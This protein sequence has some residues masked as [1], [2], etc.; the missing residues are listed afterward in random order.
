MG[1]QTRAD[2]TDPP[3]PTLLDLA[4][5]FMN[6]GLTSVGSAAAPLRHV[7][8]RRRRWYSENDF[9]EVQ[10]LAQALPGAVGINVAVMTGDRY[11]RPFGPLAAAAGLV[12]PSLLVAVALATV[13]TRLAAANVRF[14]AAET[15]VTAAV[16]G[17]LLSNGLR[18]VGLL[19]RDSPD[20][21]FSW[22]A[23]RLGISLLGFVLITGLHVPIQATLLVLIPVSFY[24]ETRRHAAADAT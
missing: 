4:L 15:A 10:G 6:V 23:A 24:V 2:V 5:A 9:A 22:R 20:K 14:A 19:W 3:K 12:V 8:V 13:A 1:A 17:M 11:A 21:R 18:L 7:L 16:A